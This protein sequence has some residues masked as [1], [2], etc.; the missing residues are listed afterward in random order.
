MTLARTKSCCFEVKFTSKRATCELSRTGVGALKR[1]PP[2]LTQRAPDLQSLA[3][4][5]RAAGARAGAA[6]GAGPPPRRGRPPAP[7]GRVLSAERG[8]D[9]RDVGRRE[10]GERA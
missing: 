6:C 3:G 4:Y 1:K 10:R 9:R 2:A 7:G 8:E 5:L